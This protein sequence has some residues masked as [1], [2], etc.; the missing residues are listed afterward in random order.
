M[1]SNKILTV[2]ILTVTILLTLT[3]TVQVF[4]L[5]PSVTVSAPGTSTTGMTATITLAASSPNIGGS[6]SSIKV[7]WGDGI[8]PS[9][10][11]GTTTSG[12]HL[13]STAGTYTIT[14]TA[15]DNQG[16]T[17]SKTQIIIVSAP[18]PGPSITTIG[19]VVIPII[20]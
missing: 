11:S 10:L 14:V 18:S 6:I 13:Y 7:D 3:R 4:G 20:G 8:D 17:T 15:T 2:A 16:M 19:L 12:S 1:K 5:P 9:S